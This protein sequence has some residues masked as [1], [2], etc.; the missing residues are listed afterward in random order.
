MPPLTPDT[1]PTEVL[2][3]LIAK[4][5]LSDS[6]VAV[7]LASQEREQV[8]QARLEWGG[9]VAATVVV[10]SLTIASLL[11]IMNGHELSGTLFATAD[12]TAIASAFLH[13][14]RLG[15]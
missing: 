3:K 9:L 5:V 13:H 15:K 7:L 6:N 10:L 2:L 4:G 8:R 11:L 12:L 14:R 1:A